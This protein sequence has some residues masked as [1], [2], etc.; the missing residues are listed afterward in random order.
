M[1]HLTPDQT[2]ELHADIRRRIELQHTMAE[3]TKPVL[4]LEYSLDHSTIWHI[5]TGQLQERERSRIPV[6]VVNEVVRRRTIWRLAK[7]QMQD[8]LISVL[9]ERYQIS[10]MSVY[11]HIW[12]V[13]DEL[14]QEMG[15]M[16]A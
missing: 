13:R 9:A 16:A 2:A 1:R 5:E 3:H 8:Y 6:A 15:A 7:E 12:I 11:R 14:Q 10:V 4:E